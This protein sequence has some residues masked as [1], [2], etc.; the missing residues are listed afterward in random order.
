[1][2]RQ[3]FFY[4]LHSF[5]LKISKNVMLLNIESISPYFPSSSSFFLLHY[6]EIQKIFF[7]SVKK[8]RRR[9]KRQQ[10]IIVWLYGYK[11]LAFGF[12]LC[13]QY[14]YLCDIFSVYFVDWFLPRK[15]AKRKNKP[16][17]FDNYT[18]LYD[19]HKNSI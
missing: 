8:R 2:K 13:N 12:G 5:A 11:I 16:L 15:E 19:F 4:L 3:F 17:L 18:H 1:M 9:K 10:S 7:V 14:K 6:I